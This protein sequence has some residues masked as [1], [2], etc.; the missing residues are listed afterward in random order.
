MNDNDE[1]MNDEAVELADDQLAQVPA[2]KLAQMLREKRR[3]EGSYRTQ[4]REAEAERDRLSAAVSGY[5]RKSFDE[6]ARGRKV[7]DSAVDE[8]A[9]KL[10]VSELLDENGQED[11]E[12][13]G[14][15][16]DELKRS[17]PH[18]FKAMPM[19]SSVD[20]SSYS[21]G[22]LIESASWGDVLG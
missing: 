5:Q 3:S 12:K 10:D 19:R 7:L 9:E 2:E 20:T 18:F 15:A 14:A 4:L 8:V 11:E 16:L 1:T 21:T 17:K 13:A 22:D 6:F